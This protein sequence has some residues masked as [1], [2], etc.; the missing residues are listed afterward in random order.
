MV[1]ICKYLTLFTISLILVGCASRPVPRPA[2]TD[3]PQLED[4]WSRI[5]ITSG[6]FSWA[7]LWTTEQLGP[8]FINDQPVW[9][10][11]KDEYIVIDLL[12]GSY[13]LSWTPRASD[14]VYTEKRKFIF[15]AGETRHFACD[16]AEKGAGMYF[17]LIGALASEYLTKTYLEE[18]PMDNPNS[19][20]VAYKVFNEGQS[21]PK[22]YNKTV[23]T[24]APE[25]V[26]KS[27]VESIGDNSVYEKLEKLKKM[28]E[29]NL[30]TKEEYDSKRKELVNDF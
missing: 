26:L 11:A 27:E 28:Y 7:R 12:P 15:N 9:E 10:A 2:Y 6:K 1:R 17:G 3:L 8:V 16:Q 19:T 24:K 30:I 4:G 13:E 21:A 5:K 23:E 29:S 14:K 25:P 18:R 22:S 20:L